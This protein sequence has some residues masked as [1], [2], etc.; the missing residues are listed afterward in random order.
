MVRF[1]SR[2]SLRYGFALVAVLVASLIAAPV[3]KLVGGR[4]PFITYFPLV[5]LVRVI[6]GP[7]PGI[8]STV[9]SALAVAVIWMDVLR[10]PVPDKSADI[11]S[12]VLYLLAGTIITIV[13]GFLRQAQIARRETEGLLWAL[14]DNTPGIMYLKDRA[15]KLR[16]INRRFAELAKKSVED[17]I[18]KDDGYAF[19]DTPDVQAFRA[20]DAMVLSSGHVTELEE[21]MQRPDGEHTYLSI[22]VPIEYEGQ[23]VLCGF[24]TD[25]TDRKRA[26]LRDR[27]LLAWMMQSV[28]CRMRGKSPVPLRE[29][30]ANISEWI[31]APMPMW[32]RI[33]T[34]ST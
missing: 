18:G 30:S 11:V 16:M 14:V 27:F 23:T 19:G 10:A 17:L 25:I 1:I 9:L 8:F 22:K 21:K 29:C 3:Q 28:H 2:R 34:P 13:G 31:A 32:P 20:N 15:G 6:A 12:L 7:G 5:M 24:S 4:V 33:R 26:E